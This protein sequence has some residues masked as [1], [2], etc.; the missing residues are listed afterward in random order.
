MLSFIFIPSQVLAL[1]ET[2]GRA[3]QP[4]TLPPVPGY[5]SWRVERG[6]GDKGGGGLCILYR[7]TLTPHLWTPPVPAHVRH[8]ENE[9]QWFLIDNGK[10]K[11]A[12]LHCYLACQSTKNDD[13]L[14]WNEDLFQLM[15]MEMSKLREHGF[16]TLCMGDFNSRV[17]RIQGLENNTPDVNKN[18]PMFM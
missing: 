1:S 10:E 9:R 4:W 5:Q 16:V 14:Q 15:S 12:F 6:G 11:L 2:F 13:F 18:E 7:E 8:V 3:D 17:G